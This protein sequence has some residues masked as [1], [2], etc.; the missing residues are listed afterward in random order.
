MDVKKL[1]KVQDLRESHNFRKEVK[2]AFSKSGDRLNKTLSKSMMHHQGK[3][4]PKIDPE[5][6]AKIRDIT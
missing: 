4:I 2:T 1:D 5:M 6:E 3:E